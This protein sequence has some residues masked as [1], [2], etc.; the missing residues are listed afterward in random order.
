MNEQEE[1][2]EEVEELKEEVKKLNKKMK[3]Q[4]WMN[5]FLVLDK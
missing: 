1:I 5:L 4:K 2:N 3:R